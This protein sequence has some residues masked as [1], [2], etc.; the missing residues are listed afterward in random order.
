[1]T[2]LRSLRKWLLGAL[3]MF[4]ALEVGIRVAR[5][6]S[7]PEGAGVDFPFDGHH[8]DSRLLR[9]L[10]AQGGGFE[11]QG[12][13]MSI[14]GQGRRGTTDHATVRRPDK[15]LRI[16][17][18]GTGNA[19]GFRVPD[20]ATWPE[21]LEA[22]LGASAEVLNLAYPGSTAVWLDR[23]IVD[24]ALALSPDLV[25]VA[26]AG[27]NEALRS[28]HRESDYIGL[29]PRL[30]DLARGSALFRTLEGRVQRSRHGD[31]PALKV[32][33]REY[34][35]L[36]GAS[37][38]RLQAGGVRVVLMQ[39]VVVYPDVPPYW[40]LDDLPLYHAAMARVAGETGVPVFDPADVLP[41]DATDLFVSRLIYNHEACTRIGAGLAQLLREEGLAPTR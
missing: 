8:A 6:G 14:N 23:V 28:W 22:E 1:M 7:D 20:G 32:P 13:W 19:Y 15:P 26:Y 40:Y 2:R 38:R 35:A 31:P 10:M 11:D 36:L 3:A 41:E 21:Q 18:A 24:E 5:V 34:D 9:R 29:A 37:V 39:E 4:L 33:V 12:V 25:V 27:Y 16:V 17:V 30:I